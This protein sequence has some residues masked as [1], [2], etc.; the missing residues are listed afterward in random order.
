MSGA[1]TRLYNVA[2]DFHY[3]NEWNSEEGDYKPIGP[4]GLTCTLAIQ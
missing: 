3:D 2:F 4:T 1:E